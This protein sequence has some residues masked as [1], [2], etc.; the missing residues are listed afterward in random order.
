MSCIPDSVNRHN[1]IILFDGVCRLCSGW[2][3]FVMERDKDARFMFAS[4]QSAEGQELLQWLG[5]P[6]DSYD[7]MVYIH[8][9]KAYYR[10]TAFLKIVPA[11]GWWWKTFAHLALLVPRMLRDWVYDRIALNRYVLFG[12]RQS[13]LM[14]TPEINERFL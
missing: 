7:T 9:G 14:P 2:V 4:V 11:F 1:D 8:N 10:S 3:F 13:C 6:T 12:R 5:L